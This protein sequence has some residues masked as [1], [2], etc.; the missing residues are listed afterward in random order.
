MVI[1]TPTTKRPGKIIKASTINDISEPPKRKLTQPEQI[2]E[3][4][5]T[6]KRSSLFQIS[7]AVNLSA[8]GAEIIGYLETTKVLK[9]IVCECGK[10]KIYELTNN[11]K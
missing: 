5:K 6:H 1:C 9:G 7:R 2:I 4:L 3:Y 8:H 11:I 10:D